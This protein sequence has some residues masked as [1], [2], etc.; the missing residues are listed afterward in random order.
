LSRLI[1]DRKLLN[2]RRGG[3]AAR[4]VVTVGAL[5]ATWVAFARLGDS[6]WQLIVAAV[7][8]FLF[9]QVAFI[10][11]DA[12][13]QQIA[14][15]RRAND[16]LG[17]VIA[18]LFVGLS[19]GWWIGEHNRHHARPN[20]EGYDPDIGEGVLAFTT[21][22]AAARNGPV[23]R[24][25][26]RHQAWLFFPLL[27]L[28]G[29]NLHVQAIGWLRRSQVSRYRRTEYVLLGLHAIA[30]FGAL[31]VVL[32]PL[33]VLAFVAIHQAVWG[34]YM[35]CSFA[36]NH[37]GM[38][39]VGS[40]SDLD[41]LRRQVL[42]TRNVR[43]N[44]VTDFLLGGLNYQVEHH[45]FPN[46]PRANLRAAQPIVRAYCSDLGVTYSETTLIGS[47]VCALRY[48]H[49]VGAGLRDTS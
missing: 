11:H 24:F 25:I 34:I 12:G 48:L 35:G 10:G 23:S 33:K 46:M 15:S 18:D 6:W 40:D 29:I 8:G 47:Y 41:F 36:P 42:T 39:T 3:Y 32:S 7:L 4:I 30:Y 38:P 31:L 9:T 22:Q 49:S 19:Y 21:D 27:T 26:A 13:H 14:R 45:L 44:P 37:K 1:R 5:A 20:Q 2:R 28:E 16:Q 43:G 17:L